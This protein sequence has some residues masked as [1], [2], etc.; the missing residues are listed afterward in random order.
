M[1]KEMDWQ[2]QC[3]FFNEPPMGGKDVSDSA[4]P[5]APKTPQI[6]TNSCIDDAVCSEPN[7]SNALGATNTSSSMLV[8]RSKAPVVVVRA[9]F[10]P[11]VNISKPKTIATN[12]TAFAINSPQRGVRNNVWQP[13][14]AS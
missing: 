4:A 10:R 9:C 12:V 2:L 7:A 8:T 5:I 13:K 11:L 6:N 3:Y 14:T 1:K